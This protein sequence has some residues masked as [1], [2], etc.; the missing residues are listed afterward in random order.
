MDGILKTVT[1]ILI[2]GL[3]LTIIAPASSSAQNQVCDPEFMKTLRDRAWMQAQREI[4][5]NN[6][7]I[8]KPD[9]VLKL[10]CFDEF[11][12]HA[13]GNYIF[14]S[15]EVPPQESLN[16]ALGSALGHTGNG[17]Q[18]NLQ[19]GELDENGDLASSV[20]PG[21]YGNCM[22]MQDVWEAVQ[23]NNISYASFVELSDFTEIDP[24]L[25]T[26]PMQCSAEAPDDNTGWQ[27]ALDRMRTKAVGIDVHTDVDA[28][29][30]FDSVKLF[31]DN[32]AP[33]NQ[34][35]IN[36]GESTPVPTGVKVNRAGQ[37]TSYNEKI[38]P[39]PGCYYAPSSNEFEGD[40]D[41]G[42]CEPI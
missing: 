23:C 13:A 5:L 10:T 39:N 34:T 19:G 26:T 24:D 15:D 9:S 35:D 20:S 2:L 18:F 41:D 22:A 32:W 6:M 8:N 38:C 3:C 31:R 30:Y 33:I 28:E 25:R 37:Q 16:K 11:L 29:E 21:N 40:L 1:S 17:F 36:C 14:A 4:E 7:I 42:S 27:D 12:N